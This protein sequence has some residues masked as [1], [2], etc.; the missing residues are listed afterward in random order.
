MKPK[1]S[2]I[3][4]VYNGS[5]YLKEA[6]ESALAQT[7]KNIEIL[8]IN[9]GSSDAGK[10]AKIAKSYLPRIRYYEKENGGV[11]SALNFGIRKMKGEYFSW[12]SHDDV[13]LPDKIAFQLE[14]IKCCPKKAVLYSNFE[15]INAKGRHLKMFKFRPPKAHFIY[16]L[17]DEKF[18]NGCTILVSKKAFKETGLFNEKLNNVPD[19]EMWYRLINKG[20]NFYHVP[21]VLVKSRVHSQQSGQLKKDVQ[22]VE[23]DYLYGWLLKN[24]PL[25][26]IFDR[27][28]NRT[29]KYL[30]LSLKFKKNKL[31]RA[32][33]YSRLLAIRYFSWRNLAQNLGLLIETFRRAH[34]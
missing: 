26:K 34:K 10:T 25:E 8:V 18:I 12:L 3:I 33:S 16:Y 22:L 32:A 31:F 4:P 15:L 5:N 2:I 7:Y 27:V 6:I 17:I 13:Y 29:F 24:M 19:Y 11:A 9:D 14:F 23:E 21:K 20:Y 30:S 28:D 1:V